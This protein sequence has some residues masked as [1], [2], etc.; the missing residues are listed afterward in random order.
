METAINRKIII[1]TK[2]KDLW[3]RRIPPN[4]L[5]V[6]AILCENIDYEKGK[7][8]SVMSGLEDHNWV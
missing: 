6:E 7:Q 1:P 4:L 8:K 3:I 5:I 2:Q